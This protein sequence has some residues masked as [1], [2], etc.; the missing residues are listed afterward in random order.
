[1]FFFFF[2]NLCLHQYWLLVSWRDIELIDPFFENAGSNKWRLLVGWLALCRRQRV[3]L[4]IRLLQCCR[5]ELLVR[6]SNLLGLDVLGRLLGS[7][8]PVL[9]KVGP[10]CCR[11]ACLR[12]EPGCLTTALEAGTAGFLQV[13]VFQICLVLFKKCI[14]IL[15]KKAAL[16]RVGRCYLLL[17]QANFTG[18][19]LKIFSFNYS[20][21]VRRLN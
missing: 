12:L 8:L 15:W 1:M 10:F 2:C 17:G 20:T 18:C 21:T 11:A 14:L 3:I 4:S 5:G 19:L 16:L 7:F 6:E 13:Q 9:C